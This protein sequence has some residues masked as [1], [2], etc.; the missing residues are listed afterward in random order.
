MLRNSLLFRWISEKFW[1]RWVVCDKG[2]GKKGVPNW[3]VDLLW[4]PVALGDK[5][6]NVIEVD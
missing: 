6:V 1:V 3:D 2:G 4:H 5:F